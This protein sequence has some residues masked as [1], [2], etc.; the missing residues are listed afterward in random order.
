[1]IEYAAILHD[2]GKIGIAKEILHKKAPLLEKEVLEIKKHP[3]LGKKI[4][5]PLKFLKDA[6]TLIDHHQERYDGSGYPGGLSGEEI[7]LGA[8]VIAIADSFDAMTSVR[9]YRKR[10][11]MDTTRKELLENA[12]KQFD[13]ALV[14]VFIGL[15]DEGVFDDIINRPDEPENQLKT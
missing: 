14:R 13:P 7:P 2:I 1:M 3:S 5:R 8:R 11:S 12:G 6:A 9:P 10:L 15:I 4:L